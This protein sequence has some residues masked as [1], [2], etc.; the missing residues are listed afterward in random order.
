MS[1]E[2]DVKS[3]LR[4]LM[5]AIKEEIETVEASNSI[6]KSWI[7]YRRVKTKQFI[8]DSKKSVISSYAPLL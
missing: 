4:L 5:G 6:E 8:Y 2:E 1:S 7:P 3:I